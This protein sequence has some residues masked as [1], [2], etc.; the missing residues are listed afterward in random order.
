LARGGAWPKESAVV[1][2]R[3]PAAASQPATG[4]APPLNAHDPEKEAVTTERHHATPIP[5]I[6]ANP[7]R[8]RGR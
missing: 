4:G 8:G 5:A 2:R 1:D 3:Q 6:A 7:A